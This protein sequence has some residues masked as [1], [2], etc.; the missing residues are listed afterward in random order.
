MATYEYNDKLKFVFPSGFMLDRSENDDGDEVVNILAG[1]Y[2]D[3]EGETRYAFRCQLTDL[4]YDLDDMDDDI[5]SENLFDV[6]TN[7]FVEE[8]ARKIKVADDPETYFISKPIPLQIFGR[9]MKMYGAVT[10]IRF[11]DCTGIN[12]ISSN[13]YKDD[14]PEE[15]AK[16]CEGVYEVL[17]SIR[18]DGKKIPL[19]NISPEIIQKVIESSFD[20][21][22]ET[23]DISDRKS[24]V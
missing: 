6:V 12:F 7:R 15:N 1:E 17:K 10:V 14:E 22:S 3:D 20:C 5:T 2:E 8:G 9:V 13:T 4:E 16:V 18:I 19:D 11:S 24:V 23:I 21:D